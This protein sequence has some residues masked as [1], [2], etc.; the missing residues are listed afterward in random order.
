MLRLRRIK[1]VSVKDGLL[2]AEAVV[3]LWL[4]RLGLWLLPF[5]RLTSFLGWLTTSSSV[6]NGSHIEVRGIRRC[7]R[8]ASRVVPYPTCLTQA[9][10]TRVLLK[11]RGKVPELRIGVTKNDVGRLEAHAWLESDGVV[12]VGKVPGLSRYV[13]IPNVERKIL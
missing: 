4:V 5:T 10:A 12:V 13:A 8:V 7:I 2:I 1:N 9:L 11:R 6:R 3:L